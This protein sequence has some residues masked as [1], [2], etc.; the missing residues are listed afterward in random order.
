M[1]RGVPIKGTHR[2]RIVALKTYGKLIRKVVKRIKFMSSIEVFAIFF[3]SF[4]SHVL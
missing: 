4:A 2:K 3:I 1:F